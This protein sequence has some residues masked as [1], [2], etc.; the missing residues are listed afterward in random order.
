MWNTL[1]NHSGAF[2]KNEEISAQTYH[3]D[4]FFDLKFSFSPCWRMCCPAG[5]SRG[6]PGN[7]QKTYSRTSKMVGYFELSVPLSGH[8]LRGS[9]KWDFEAEHIWNT[10]RSIWISFYISKLRCA[11]PERPWSKYSGTR[12]STLK[13]WQKLEKMMWKWLIPKS[14][15]I[16]PRRFLDL[17]DIKKHEKTMW[18]TLQNHSGR[19]EKMTKFRLK[20]II[21]MIFST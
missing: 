3:S 20:P 12:H 16:I 13:K 1:Q 15:R 11:N 19:S 17:Q 18:N 14:F 4:D 5:A 2:R 8:L 10:F 7:S 21:L 9:E 6:K